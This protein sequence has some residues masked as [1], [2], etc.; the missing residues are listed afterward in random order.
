M[1]KFYNFMIDKVQSGHTMHEAMA[2]YYGCF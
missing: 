1:I 2:E